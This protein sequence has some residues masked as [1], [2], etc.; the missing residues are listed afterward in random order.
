MIEMLKGFPDNVV[1]LA[2]KGHVTRADYDK[3]LVPAV[4]EALKRQQKVRLYYEIGA[5]FEGIDPGAVWE[6]F[7]VGMGH[8]FRWERVAVVTDVEWIANTM[9]VFGF[10]M[11]VEIKLFPVS[12]AK[13]ARDWLVA[14]RKAA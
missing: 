2:C 5:D 3:V 6:D 9:K 11:P 4:E 13:E 10:L 8:L 1:A 7:M 12:R 14:T